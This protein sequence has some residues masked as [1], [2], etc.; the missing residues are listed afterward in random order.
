MPESHEGYAPI[1]GVCEDF[2]VEAFRVGDG[3]ED[4]VEFFE[5]GHVFFC[6]SAEFYVWWESWFRAL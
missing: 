3:Q 4:A 2:F 5:R 6:W 1:H